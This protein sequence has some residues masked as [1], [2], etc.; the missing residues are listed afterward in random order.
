[1]TAHSWIDRVNDQP[2][3]ADPQEPPRSG[4]GATTAAWL[5]YA[6]SLGYEPPA[7]VGRA[8]LIA[9]VDAGPAST[10]G[11]IEAATEKAIESA[12]H[13]T[14]V[15]AGAVAV[16]RDL[17][18]TIDTM[19][20]RRNAHVD[21]VTKPTYLKYAAELGLTPLSRNRLG[22]KEATG[23][24]KLAQLRAIQGGKAS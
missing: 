24:S 1:M 22:K 6:K 9:M 16:L 4:R 14:D 13:L 12:D 17:A 10:V 8:E 21:N 23:G 19:S 20:G 7:S 11:P 3:P 2:R 18:R 15:D 5:T